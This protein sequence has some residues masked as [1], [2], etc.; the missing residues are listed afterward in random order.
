MLRL[1]LGIRAAFMMFMMC[2]WEMGHEKQ[3]TA[4][5]WY[6]GFVI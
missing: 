2:I 6:L 4:C 5:L 3:E 1:R